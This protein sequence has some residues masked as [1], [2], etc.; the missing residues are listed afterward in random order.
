MMEKRTVA[1]HELR[2]L[3]IGQ[4]PADFADWLD[5]VAIAALLAF[6][7]QAEPYVFAILAISMGL[8]YLIVGPFAGLVVDRSDT[9]T[10]LV[11]SNLGRALVTASFF[12]APDWPY[13][14]ILIAL[15]SSV[16]T[17][18]TPSKQSALQA[19]TDRDDRARVNAFSHGINQASKIVAPAIGGSLLMFLSPQMVFL[20]N[21]AVSLLAAAIF[22]NLAA[23]PAKTAP[24]ETAN[25]GRLATIRKG[26]SEVFGSLVLRSAIS[27]MAAGYFAMF[28]YDTLIAPLTRDL[29][30]NQTHLGLALAAVGGGGVL[31]AVGLTLLRQAPRPFVMIASG[32]LLSGLI[33][34]GLGLAEILGH[35]MSLI[36]F[37]LAFGV[38]GIASALS[39]VPFCTVMQNHTKEGALGQITAFSEAA[40]TIALLTAPLIGAVVA[41]LFSIGAAFVLGGVVML[42]VFARAVLLRNLA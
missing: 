26:M 21:A 3:L 7:W 36:T 16:D 22:L 38:L 6:T 17:F 28:F 35:P 27:M 11:W 5:F 20:M 30:F 18:F 19:L 34:I 41:S 24:K 15:R 4:I 42:A 39:V 2:R 29:G 25:E 32:S 23:L 37:I 1:N 40:N 12:I 14:M 9:R 13:L 31:G 10:V 8:P 33:V